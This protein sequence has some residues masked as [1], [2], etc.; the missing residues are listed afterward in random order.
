MLQH[1][2]CPRSSPETWEKNDN[3]RYEIDVT[4]DRS[5]GDA[6]KRVE[7]FRPQTNGSFH[8]LRNSAGIGR[9]SGHDRHV[10]KNYA[11]VLNTNV[12][13]VAIEMD[14]P[15]ARIDT[16]IE[17][18]YHHYFFNARR[19]VVECAKQSPAQVSHSMFC[20]QGRVESWRWT[21]RGIGKARWG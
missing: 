6:L 20:V 1:W 5:I 10:H 21:M 14:T 8:L 17:S 15:P 16:Q 9:P 11:T 18:P 3:V 7:E 19:V 13:S 4:N 12:T 2:S